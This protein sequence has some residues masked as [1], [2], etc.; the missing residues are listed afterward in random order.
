MKKYIACA[1]GLL[2]FACALAQTYPV[3][4]VDLRDVRLTDNFW[5]PRIRQIQQVT[6]PVAFQRCEAEGR[7]ENFLAAERV[8]NSGEGKVRGKMPFDD[9]DVYKIIEGAS[10]SL[11]SNPDPELEALLD[12][13]IAIV[14]RGQEPDGYLTTWRTIDPTAPPARWVGECR[15]RWDNLAMSHELY[16]AGH[17]F[18]AAAAHYYATGKRNFLDIAIKYAD[19]IV[20]VFGAPDNYDVPGHEIIETG[21][22]KLYQIT[23]QKAYF[24]LAKKF[25]DLRGDD[26]HRT[27]R[28]AYWQD[29][30]PIL[31]HN[32]AVG[33][34]VRAVYYYA[35]VTDIAAITGDE[36]YKNAAGRLW[37]NMVDR[38]MY[39]TGGLGARHD[40]E[41][42]GENYELPNLTAYNETCAA[43]GGVMWADR[44]F[45]LFGGADYYNVLERMLYNGVISGISLDGTSFF[46]PNPLESDGR[47]RFNQGHLTRAGWFDCSC[48]PTNLIRFLP[49]LPDLIYNFDEEAIYLNL[50]VSSEAKIP[51]GKNSIA[52]SQTTGYP[53]DGK[54][55]IEIDPRRAAEFTLKIRIPDWATGTF[56]SELYT[57]ENGVSAP[58][59]VLLN[60]KEMTLAPIGG[61]IEI[62]RKWGKGDRVEVEFPMEVRTIAASP[63]IEDDRGKTAVQYGPMVYCMEEIDNPDVYDAGFDADGFR[64]EFNE[65]KLG[66]V[67]E[68]FATDGSRTWDLIPYHTWSNRGE[69]RMKVWGSAGA[70]DV[71]GASAYLMVYFTDP[72]HSLFMATSRDGHTFTAVNDA[73]PIAAGDTLATQKGIR[74]PHIC[75]GPDGAFYMAMTDLHIAGQ[76]MG[77]RTTQWERDGDIYDWGNNRG[78]VLMKSHDLVNWTHASVIVQDTFPHLDVAC[79]WAPETI[80]DPVE[81]KMMLYFT[82]RLTGGKTRLYYAYTD[83]DFTRLVS[84][85]KLLFEYPDPKVQILDADITPLPDGRYCM[86]YVAQEQPGGIKMAFSDRI[87][88]GYEYQELW[89]DSEPG[90]CEAPNVFKRI[91]D[92]KWVLMYDVFSIRPHNFG[93]VETSD[94]KT[95]T[96][97]GRFNEGVMKTTNFTSPKHG[98]IIQITAAEA[99]RLEARFR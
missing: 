86:M 83:D 2:S 85:P 70:G 26:T 21:L 37:N 71:D 8:M 81:G 82:M 91:G 78:F 59:R 88:G 99:D 46:Y 5:L 53:L 52:I 13:Y 60:G 41:A 15:E 72:T 23:G 75:R 35:G 45:R 30:K 32:E 77:Y 87:N 89:A 38:K 58:V 17:L 65:A 95:F 47:Y 62:D 24:D 67:N 43:I 49:S 6:I 96:P 79:A 74:D 57:Y 39:V 10:L 84:E 1:V 64:V 51:L 44:M 4:K 22:V 97:L 31:Q 42:F 93:F 98:A 80:Y 29:D 50:F 9:T 55:G 25:I 68:I 33:H 40:G 28:G 34:A 73:R 27:P 7:F 66:G 94:F 19:L 36:N 48:C 63:L 54:V 11:V 12:R 61:Y 69:G 56:P 76:R 14:A 92:N 3:Q 18:E 20:K 16:N 90:A